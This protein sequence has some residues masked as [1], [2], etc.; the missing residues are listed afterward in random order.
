[1]ENETV[2]PGCCVP[3]LI[4]AAETEIASL[5]DLI[6]SC[7]PGETEAVA[8]YRERIERYGTA[9]RRAVANLPDRIWTLT[10]DHGHGTD[11]RA[12]RTEAGA[13]AALA[14]WARQWWERESDWLGPDS[15]HFMPLKDFEALSDGEAVSHYFAAMD[16]RESYSV[17]TCELGD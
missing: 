9:V 17:D 2:P 13:L 14:A 4:K 11:T 3:D 7:G 15:P 16:S 5:H 1:M 12:F 8:D 10:I 6:D